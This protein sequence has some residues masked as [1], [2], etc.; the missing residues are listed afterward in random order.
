MVSQR[1]IEANPDKIREVMEVKFP[2]IVNEVQSLAG[3]VAALNK[4]VSR[5]TDK[6]LPFFKVLKKAF[7][8]T[9]ECEEALSKLKE[10]LTQPPF[11]SPSIIGERLRLYLVVWNT[12]VNSALIGEE[13]EV[14]RPVYYTSQAF[15][16]AEANYPRL[17]KIAFTMVVASRK[18]RHY[19][20]AN[21]IVIMIDQLIRKTMN[22]IDAAGCLVQWAIKL[23]Q[24]DIEY[25]PQ[26]AIKS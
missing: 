17:E 13:E 20:H 12:A 26:I 2:K 8:W 21:L 10:Y 16:G 24:F 4:F 23:G 15:Q 5:A 11:L 22:E 25:R 1:G 7:Q 19:F 6:C 14:Q 18:L 3:K 9:D